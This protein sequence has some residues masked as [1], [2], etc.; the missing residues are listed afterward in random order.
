MGDGL[1]PPEYPRRP[2]H[3]PP[4]GSAD[5]HAHVFGPFDRFPLAAARPYTPHELP[6]ERYLAML[7]ALGFERGV[8]VQPVAHGTDCGAL[9]YALGLARQRLRGIA[10]LDADIS[11][12]ALEKLHAAGVRGA[13]FSAP[14]PGLAQG[15]VGFEVLERQAPRLKSL[16]WHAQI[17]A[18]CAELETVVRRL[19]PLGLP[20]VVDHMGGFEAARGVADPHFQALLRLLDH[21]RIWLKLIPYRL[22]SRYPNYEDI[23][24]FHHALIATHP[25]RLIWGSDWPHVHLDKDM[26]DAGHLV[27]LFCDWTDDWSLRQQILVENPATLY[28]FT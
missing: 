23:A 25:E 13:R 11:D 20:L 21:G 2:R 27:D 4:F 18:P 9:L 7:D 12:E 19:V 14:P 8:L 10:L 5:C 16:G 26:P 24:P 17:W 1:P 22:S 3:P 28:G 15:A 6:G